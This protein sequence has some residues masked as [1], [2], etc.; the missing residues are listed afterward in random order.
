LFA[1]NGNYSFDWEIK[2][3]RKGYEDFRVIRDQDELEVSLPKERNNSTI[4]KIKEQQN[5]RSLRKMR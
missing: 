2:C 3:V 4:Q 5:Q 1:G